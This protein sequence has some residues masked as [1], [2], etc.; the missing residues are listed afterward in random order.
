MVNLS[1]PTLILGVGNSACGK[2][3]HLLEVVKRVDNAFWIDKDTIEDTFLF[4]MN[5]YS[6]NIEKYNTILGSFPRK[7]HHHLMHVELQSYLLMLLKAKNNLVLGKHPVLDGNYIR[8]IPKGYIEKIIMPILSGINY[9][10]KI[11]YFHCPEE[12][13]KKRIIERNNPRDAKKLSNEKIWNEFLKK[14]PIMIKE[15]EKYDHLKVDSSKELNE[16]INKILDYLKK[17]N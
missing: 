3:I 14:E 11:L 5:N 2:T 8:E 16:N 1:K 17:D 9:K 12:I 6:N 7:E 13:M 4:K 10:L 15:I